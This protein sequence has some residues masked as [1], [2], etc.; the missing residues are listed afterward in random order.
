MS[1]NSK[2]LRD[3]AMLPGFLVDEQGNWLVGSDP[4]TLMHWLVGST[5]NSC[6]IVLDINS[7]MSVASFEARQGGVG[8]GGRLGAVGANVR[9]GD[10]FTKQ[11]NITVRL[12]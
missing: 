12:T 8:L 7:R 6:L 4:S 1:G 5:R 2:L 3:L 11:C 10:W 9:N